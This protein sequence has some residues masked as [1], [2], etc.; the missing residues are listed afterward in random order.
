VESVSVKC[1]YHEVCNAKQAIAVVNIAQ[2]TLIAVLGSGSGGAIQ[3][4]SHHMCTRCCCVQ[5]MCDKLDCGCAL[6]LH[7]RHKTA[8]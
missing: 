5:Y 1:C 8:L 4:A 6:K 7:Y 2:D 3:C